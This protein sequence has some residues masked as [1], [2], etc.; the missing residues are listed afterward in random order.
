MQP[1]ERKGEESNPLY[2]NPKFSLSS[3][4]LLFK[5]WNKFYFLFPPSQKNFICYYAP[6]PKQNPWVR[7]V[8]SGS[9]K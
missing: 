6:P 3:G 7:G 8:A 4:H 5:S 1:R 2:K 9:G